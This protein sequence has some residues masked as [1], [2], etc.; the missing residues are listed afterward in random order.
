[1]EKRNKINVDVSS[2]LYF[3]GFLLTCGMR[4]AENGGALWNA[5]WHGLLSWA[6]VGYWLVNFLLHH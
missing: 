4:F 5:I 3:T 6:Y 1:M 2:G